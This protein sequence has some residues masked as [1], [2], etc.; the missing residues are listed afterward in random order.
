MQELLTDFSFNH[1]WIYLHS[2]LRILTASSVQILGL[3]RLSIHKQTW[4]SQNW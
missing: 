3:E 1:A 4:E 2:H